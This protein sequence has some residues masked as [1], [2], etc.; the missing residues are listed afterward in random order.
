[1]GK[2]TPSFGKRNKKTHIRCRRCGNRSYHVRNKTCASCGF[3][4]SKR[5]RRY[6]WQNKKINGFRLK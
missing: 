4:S 2:G 6:N 5:I 1:M 3:G